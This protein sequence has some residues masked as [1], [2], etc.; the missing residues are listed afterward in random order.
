MYLIQYNIFYEMIYKYLSTYFFKLRLILN[1]MHKQIQI[2]TRNGINYIKT[3]KKS[4]I[5]KLSIFHLFFLIML[6]NKF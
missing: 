6:N 5:F 1:I 2:I 3:N 4:F